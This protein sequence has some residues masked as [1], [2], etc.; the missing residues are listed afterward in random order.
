[1]N[2]GKDCICLRESGREFQTE[3][4]DTVK[5]FPPK[6]FSLKRGVESKSEFSERSVL[7]GIYGL[8]ISDRY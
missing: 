1:M 2:D 5:D 6:V 8:R 3:G 4:P 7:E